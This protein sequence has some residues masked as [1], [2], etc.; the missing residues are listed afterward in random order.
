MEY[1]HQIPTLNHPT[2]IALGLFDGLH[3]GHR[4][5]IQQAV[6]CAPKLCPLVFTFQFDRPEDIT[7]PD[8]ANILTHTRKEQILKKLGVQLVCEPPFS[9]F[10]NLSPTE[11]FSEIL[12]KRLHAGAIFC[13]EDFH[14][15][16]NA[17]GDANLLHALCKQAGIH[18]YAVPPLLVDGNVV[19]STQIRHLLREGDPL[20]AAKLL[21]EPYTI[22]Y[23]VAHGRQLGRTMGF[24][25]INQ[26]FKTG[27]LIPRNGVYASVAQVGNCR[28]PAVTNVGIKPTLGG[29]DAPSAESTLLGFEGDL[30]GQ[31]IPVSFYAFLRPEQRFDSI[32]RLFRQVALDAQQ[33]EKLWPEIQAH[34]S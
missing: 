8:F 19:S 26:I 12:V 33:A 17:A 7:K 11:F 13:G 16:K 31:A 5:V 4:A 29:K 28:Y 30:Y 15:G 10:R 14:F 1:S 20:Q 9:L 23:P 22:D 25:T 32:E 3:L 24:P 6:S 18:F 27:D 21:G 2:A 34:L